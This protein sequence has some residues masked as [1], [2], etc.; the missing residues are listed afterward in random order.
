M[1][2]I[3]AESLN[4]KKKHKNGKKI[5][6]ICIIMYLLLQI[7][8]TKTYKLSTTVMYTK[9]TNNDDIKQF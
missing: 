4:L 2:L 5:N 6:K 7:N 1:K 3:K 8:I 9:M